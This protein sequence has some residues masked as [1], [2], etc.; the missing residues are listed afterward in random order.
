M[1]FDYAPI[2]MNTVVVGSAEIVAVPPSD[3]DEPLIV[4]DE[5]VRAEFGMLVSVLVEPDIDLLVKVFD[6][7][8]EGITTPSTARTP[9]AERLSVVSV[10]CPSSILPTPS[11]VEVDATNPAIGKPVALVSV[12][13]AGVPSTGAVKVGLVSVR[14]AIVV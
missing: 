11:A 8:I 13:D 5:F 14:P 3:T 9:A 10:A 7:D 4:I 12:P 1:P 6:E 2:S